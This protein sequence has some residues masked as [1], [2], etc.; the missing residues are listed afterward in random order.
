MAV[1]ADHRQGLGGLHGCSA[2][3]GGQLVAAAAAAAVPFV[4]AAMQSTLC[5]QRVQARDGKGGAVLQQRLWKMHAPFWA[6]RRCCRCL[7]LRR[8][9]V[10]RNAVAVV[11]RVQN[12][13]GCGFAV[14]D[15]QYRLSAAAAA[16]A[17][18]RV[19][20]VGLQQHSGAVRMGEGGLGPD[21]EGLGSHRGLACF[22]L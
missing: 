7:V 15:H 20:L 3:F 1:V 8:Q 5:C 10:L 14:A 18:V 6:A 12:E 4:A 9:K 19:G 16:A 22:W 21:W 2:V 17:A 11:V 13:G